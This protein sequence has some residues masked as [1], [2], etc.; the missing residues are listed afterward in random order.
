MATLLDLPDELLQEIFAHLPASSAASLGLVN[1]R[2]A[3]ISNTPLLW[4]RY[5]LDTW[6]YWEGD[7][8]YRARVKGNPL[9]APWRSIYG[10]RWRNDKK[11]VQIVNRLLSTQQSRIERMESI[12]FEFGHDAED[13]LRQLAKTPDDAEDVLA[14]RYY[15]EA[16]LG[17]IHRQDAIEIW[18]D[19]D[20]Q[21]F[22]RLETCLGAFD[23]FIQGAGGNDCN[24]RHLDVE[25][26][27][28]AQ[29]IRNNVPGIDELDYTSKATTIASQLRSMNLLGSTEQEYHYLKNNFICH[30]LKS[31]HK[32]SLPLVSTA[33]FCCIT[34]RFGLR[35]WPC[36]F[37]FH[38]HAVLES[39]QY[40]PLYETRSTQTFNP[41]VVWMDPWRHDN[42]ID[43]DT[44]RLQLRQYGITPEEVTYSYLSPAFTR[45][46]VL[47]TGRNIMRSVNETRDNHAD[48]GAQEI[49]VDAAFYS[50]LWS[51][52]LVSLGD[53]RENT[54]QRRNYIPYLLDQFKSHYPEDVRLVERFVVPMF[55]GHP[56]QN[57][58]LEMIEEH[59]LGDS[60]P[61][62]INR[63]D[64]MTQHVKFK[65]GQPFRHK[66]FEYVGVIIG[67][68]S[69]CQAGEPWIMQMRV[70]TLPKG[71]SQSFYHIL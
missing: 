32:V 61:K 48:I 27:R 8:S 70:D 50:F 69:S 71:R 19:M 64:D 53:S 60:N 45:D 22:P 41:G 25:F 10:E 16:L 63:R 20:Y 51:V 54:L 35:A 68:D 38:I 13:V 11:V 31:E 26:D 17:L 65:V 55:A 56:A 24:E 4:R 28:I 18:N 12:V 67:W 29:D 30:V 66:R 59:R 57:Q 34:Q 14:R 46:M 62:P 1:R 42:I 5:V 6:K 44:M 15:S 49:D 39:P 33:I 40:P 52:F 7:E 9:A 37:P 43:Q 36:N 23:T 58:I 3:K 21:D 2:L 47:R